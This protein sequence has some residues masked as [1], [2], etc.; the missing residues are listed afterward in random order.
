MS[1]PK[2]WNTK[3]FLELALPALTTM[4]GLQMLRVLL[5]SLVWYLGDTLEVSS[6]M[7]GVISIAIFALSFL[8]APF[9]RALGLRRALR[10]VLIGVALLRLLAQ[11]AMIQPLD[12]L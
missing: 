5:P 2:L 3:S 6:A 11:F 1:L 10:V 9:Y 4:F 12:F 8:V 7:L